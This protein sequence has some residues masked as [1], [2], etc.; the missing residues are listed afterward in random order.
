MKKILTILVLTTITAIS[1]YAQCGKKVLITGSKT[2]YLDDAGNVTR[3]EEEHTE[4]TYDSSSITIAPNDHK[5]EGAIKSTTCNW[6][7]PFKDGQTILKTTIVP[8]GGNNVDI[9]ITITGKEGK[10]TFMAE[11]EDQRHKKIRMVVD[12]FEEAKN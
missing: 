11:V 7:V 8:E 10:F 1:S 4:I 9:T 6:T 12:K 2:E 3:T 5:M